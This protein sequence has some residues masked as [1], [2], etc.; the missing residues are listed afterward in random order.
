M[1][2][3][4]E[5]FNYKKKSDMFDGKQVVASWQNTLNFFN[6]FANF[7]FSFRWHLTGNGTCFHLRQMTFF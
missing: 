4:L 7:F 1:P 3:I 5:S 6:P 2:I